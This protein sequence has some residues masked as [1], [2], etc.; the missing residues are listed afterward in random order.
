MAAAPTVQALDQIKAEYNNQNDPGTLYI[1]GEQEQ[2]SPVKRYDGSS[3]IP[4]S[5]DKKT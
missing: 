3:W 1:V 5:V 4:V 2:Y